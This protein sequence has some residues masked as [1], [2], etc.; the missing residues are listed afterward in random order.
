MSLSVTACET[1]VKEDTLP[2]SGPKS[3]Q[4]TP[5]NQALTVQWS[6]VA[7]TQGVAATYEVY[8]STGP[9]PAFAVK[10]ESI[11]APDMNLVTSAITDL[12]NYTIYYVWVKALFGGLGES[13]YS[14]TEYTAPVPPPET[15]GAITVAPLEKMLELTWDS[16][17][18]AVTYKV[19]CQPGSSPAAAPPDGTMVLEVPDTETKSG[20]VVFKLADETPLVNNTAYTLWVQAVNT[21]GVS[22]YARTSET[23]REASSPPTQAPGKPALT[24]GNKKLF[25]SWPSVSGVPEYTVSYSTNADFSGALTLAHIPANAPMVNAELTSLVNGTT[26]YVQVLSTNS[27][28]SSPP[29]EAANAIPQAKAA[30]DFMNLQSVLGKA[31]AD[32]IFA[33]D[34]PKSVW[35]FNGRPSTDRLTRFQEAAIGNLFCDGAAW[36]MRN[37]YHGDPFDFVFLNGSFVN[38][39]IPKGNITIGTLMNA[40]LPDSRSDKL[41]LITLRGDKLLELFNDVADVPHTGHGSSNTGW[42]AMVSGA[43]YT[44][45]YY[46]PPEL[47]AWTSAYEIERGTS[48]PYYHG[49]IKAGTLKINGQPI[50][51]NRDYCILTTDYLARGEWYTTFPLYGTNKNV[52]P[53]QM[54]K[55]VAEYIYD[56]GTVTPKLDGRVKIEGGVPL[57][58]PWIPGDLINTNPPAW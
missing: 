54:W 35:F 10:W 27:K 41:C 9:N 15:P 52:I 28:G 2:L 42:F 56:Q 20:A 55:A 25:V 33:V 51:V 48:E 39:P 22:A 53:L 5:R 43:S 30:I 16:V 8:Y 3:I 12:E 40:T 6:K 44:I 26:Y 32:F 36:Y 58:P 19:F 29:G 1:N 21:A 45:R 23:P 17:R 57:P 34:L 47:A 24:V 14:P 49:W 11:G 38:N 7:S 13:D 37:N 46:R 18:D 4:L 31:S 50:D